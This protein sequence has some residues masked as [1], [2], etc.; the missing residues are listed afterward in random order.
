MI[1]CDDVL[2]TSSCQLRFRILLGEMN[3]MKK[4]IIFGLNQFA[5]LLYF[6]LKNDI[7]YEVVAFSVN[8][9]Y[10]NLEFFCGKPVI[11]F[12][13][14]DKVYDNK[15]HG[16]LICIGYNKMKQ[17]REQKFREIKAKG[18]RILSYVHP[19][20]YIQ[21][22]EIGEGNI[23]MEGVN[24]GPFVKIGNGNIIY[25]KAHIAHH[26]IIGNFNFIA[27]SAAIAG[28]IFIGDNCFF[29]NNC[30]I[31]D[32]IKINNLTLVGAAAYLSKSTSACGEVYSPQRSVKLENK[33][34][35]DINLVN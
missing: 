9:E 5:E 30:T 34:S 2:N 11:S 6:N 18:Y 20:A 3:K 35:L 21:T 10:K 15:S 29:G 14:I 8:E 23:V 13:E 26:T 16:I 33:H 7:N 1:L 25:P 17:I 4:I 24:I 31:K 19:T 32:N 22:D 12:E 27:I 28:N